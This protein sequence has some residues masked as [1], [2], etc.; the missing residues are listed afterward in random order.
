MTDGSSS[1]T[2]EDERVTRHGDRGQFRKVT[3]TYSDGSPYFHGWIQI[4]GNDD[5]RNGPT[6]FPM[7]FVNHRLDP[8]QANR[9]QEFWVVGEIGP[10][11]VVIREATPDDLDAIVDLRFQSY[12]DGGYERISSYQGL[13]QVIGDDFLTFVYAVG[14][15]IVAVVYVALK[16][17]RHQKEAYIDTW[18]CAPGI[19][20]RGVGTAL[21]R[22][23][24]A[25]LMELSFSEV[26]ACCLGD[27][28]HCENVVKAF[29]NC[30]F[31]LVS[32]DRD[33]TETITATVWRKL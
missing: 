13:N 29:V 5:G 15:L 1:L 2:K 9:R 26:R 23:T 11:D 8:D 24:L 17:G 22:A 12:F 33:P 30:G 28:E 18:F 4:F 21:L 25:R 32:L 16:Q 14:E 19:R 31:S 10:D 27:E 6:I 7:N 3:I 20:R